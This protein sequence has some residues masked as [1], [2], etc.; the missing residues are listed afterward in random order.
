MRKTKR[1]KQRHGTHR[2]KVAARGIG[3]GSSVL[4][5]AVALTKAPLEN[6]HGKGLLFLGVS[7]FVNVVLGYGLANKIC[8]Y[9]P[10]S[11]ANPGRRL[12]S[13]SSRPSPTQPRPVG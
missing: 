9:K 11:I 10:V 5:A 1:R 12:T 4:R 2:L 7:V 3:D 8:H 13:E 6:R